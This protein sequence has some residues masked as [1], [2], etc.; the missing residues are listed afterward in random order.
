[1]AIAGEVQSL[2]ERQGGQIRKKA[3][4]N[5]K[6]DICGRIYGVGRRRRFDLSIANDGTC[7]VYPLRPLHCR[8][9]CGQCG[10]REQNML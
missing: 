3:A 8:T 10:D 9:M 6:P 1:M 5:L 4:D 7:A 2:L